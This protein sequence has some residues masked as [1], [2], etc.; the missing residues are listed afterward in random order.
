[1]GVSPPRVEHLWPLLHKLP[2]LVPRKRV[3]EYLPN[4]V[5]GETIRLHDRQ[6]KGPRVRVGGT[7]AMQLSYP[8]P[9]FLEYL[10]KV[11]KPEVRESLV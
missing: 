10:E 3:Q 8:A 7:G 1:M 4:T 5:S 9:Y 11:L 6:R 2:P